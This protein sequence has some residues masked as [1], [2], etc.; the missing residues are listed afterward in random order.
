MREAVRKIAP[1]FAGVRTL[2]NDN[3]IVIDYRA[4]SDKKTIVNLTNHA[5]WNLAGEGSGTILNHV[6]SLNAALHA[7]QLRP[8]PDGGHR[9]GGGN[10]AR[11]HHADGDRG[12][13]RRAGR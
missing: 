3:R 11:F 6:L 1:A 13:D 4:R 8:H 9:P 10:A 7:H 5:Y 2:T 12:A